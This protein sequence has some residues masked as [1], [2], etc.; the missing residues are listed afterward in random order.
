MLLHAIHKAGRSSLAFS[1]SMN[2]H[3]LLGTEAL[4]YSRAR[5]YPAPTE[6]SNW[7]SFM[8]PI[9]PTSDSKVPFKDGIGMA[10]SSAKARCRTVM[11]WSKQ[12]GIVL[13]GSV[14]GQDTQSQDKVA[15]SITCELAEC[16]QQIQ[17]CALL[18][19]NRTVANCR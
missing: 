18:P 13:V 3:V 8:M 16:T 11:S 17:I 15:K 12:R 6:N 14:A 5:Q 10:A 7:Q 19:C 2:F 4:A 9:F 1:R